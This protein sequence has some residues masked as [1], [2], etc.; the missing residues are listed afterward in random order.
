MTDKA[1]Y[2]GAYFSW[3]MDSYDLGAVVITA[4]I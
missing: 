1:N 3:V 4:S 2:L